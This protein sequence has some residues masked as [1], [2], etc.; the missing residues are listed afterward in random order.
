MLGCVCIFWGVGLWFSSASQ[1]SSWCLGLKPLL[2]RIGVLVIW[3]IKRIKLEGSRG[4][5]LAAKQLNHLGD[6]VS[7]PFLGVAH[8]WLKH[9]AFHLSK[10]LGFKSAS[11]LESTVRPLLFLI[12]LLLRPPYS[13]KLLKMITGQLNRAWNICPVQLTKDDL[14][15]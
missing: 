4:N 14:N 7:Y 1:S 11:G 5:Y 13:F 2:C 15:K 10:P 3:R 6:R 12:T 9:I 8:P